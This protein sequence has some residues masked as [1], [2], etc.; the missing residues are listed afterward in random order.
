[1]GR[2]IISGEH[3]PPPVGQTIGF[4]IVEIAPDQAVFEMEAGPGRRENPGETLR[5][6]TVC[7]FPGGEGEGR[8]E[9]GGEGEGVPNASPRAKLT[10]AGGERTGAGGRVR[11]AGRKKGRAEGHPRKT[12]TKGGLLRA[13]PR[14]LRGVQGKEVRGP[15]VLRAVI[16]PTRRSAARRATSAARR[17]CRRRACLACGSARVRRA[18]RRRSPTARRCSCAPA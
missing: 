1:M 8:G 9:R 6:G 14:T 5:G 16:V 7:Y 4:R 13:P 2:K 11:E 12:A 10:Q 15:S 3:P 18:A 17:A